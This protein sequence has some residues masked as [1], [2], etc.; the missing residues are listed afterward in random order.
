M[1]ELTD[2]ISHP[3]FSTAHNFDTRSDAMSLGTMEVGEHKVDVRLVSPR[4][5]G[6]TN[7]HSETD[8]NVAILAAGRG[9]ERR[10]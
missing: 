5:H 3:R 9:A 6:S 8:L 1:S 10:A 2:L 7:S 4:S